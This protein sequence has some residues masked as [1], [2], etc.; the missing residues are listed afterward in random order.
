M[1]LY[2]SYPAPMRQDDPRRASKALKAQ[3]AKQI[4][5][6]CKKEGIPIE[7]RSRDKAKVREHAN[8]LRK[9]IAPFEREVYEGERTSL[10]VR[11]F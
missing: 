6:A 2:V 9:A 1:A 5:E 7:Y 8:R 3:S 4:A 11:V 10:T